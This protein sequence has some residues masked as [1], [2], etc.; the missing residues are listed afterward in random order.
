MT[1]TDAASAEN[2][3][4]APTLKRTEVQRVASSI[5]GRIIVQV[6]TEIPVGV[7]SGWHSHPGEE[8]GYIM[9]GTVEMS[10]DGQPTLT[11]HLGDGFL[12]PPDVAHNALDIGPGVGHMLSTYIVQ[13]DQPLTTLHDAP[14]E[15]EQRG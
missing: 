1:C 13:E 8:V 7:Q 5:P 9:G 3:A 10:I 12:I 2:D 6:H 14:T 4:L 11:L 15:V